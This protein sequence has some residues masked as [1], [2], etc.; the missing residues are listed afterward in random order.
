M[1][2]EADVI[3]KSYFVDFDIN[4]HDYMENFKNYLNGDE[5]TTGIVVTEI[6]LP[7]YMLN[8]LTYFIK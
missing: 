7:I 2:F 6:L 1:F 3:L 5:R 4:S 8:K